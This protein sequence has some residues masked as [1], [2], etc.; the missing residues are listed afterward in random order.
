MSHNG[1]LTLFLR[2]QNSDVAGAAGAS[3]GELIATQLYPDTPLDQLSETEKQ[4]I[5]ALS[6]LAG[7][8]AG[9]I[10]GGDSAKPA[11]SQPGPVRPWQVF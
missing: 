11:P 10:I 7:G 6:A 2:Q 9:G 8:I 5:S 1:G 4:N 3:I